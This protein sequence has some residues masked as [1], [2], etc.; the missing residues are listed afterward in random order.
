MLLSTLGGLEFVSASLRG[1]FCWLVPGF[2]FFF[3]DAAIAAAAVYFSKTW[4]AHSRTPMARHESIFAT[5]SDHLR[6]P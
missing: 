6:M 2:V 4:G 5:A 1:G 3:A